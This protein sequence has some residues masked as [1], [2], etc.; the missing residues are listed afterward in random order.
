MPHH[1]YSSEYVECVQVLAVR[2]FLIDIG[3]PVDH[4]LFSATQAPYEV[5]VEEIGGRSFLRVGFGAHDSED[6]YC[7]DC[8]SGEV[9]Y[10]SRIDMS[11]SHV[12]ASPRQFD[13]CLRIF[14]SEIAIA[15]S[16]DE[17]IGLEALAER[18]SQGISNIDSSALREDPGFWGSILFDVANGDY[19]EEES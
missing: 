17:P 3:L 2:E 14:E 7:V 9:V 13:D 15:V 10:L 4:V 11:E 5:R 18:L 6:S 8:A 12:N 1:K 19:T 16:G